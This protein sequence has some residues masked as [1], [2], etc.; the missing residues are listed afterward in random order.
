MK[1]NDLTFKVEGFTG[2]Q[3]VHFF[4]NGYG[5][6]IVRGPYTYGG[7]EGLWELAVL[8][9]TDEEWELCYDTPITSDVIGGINKEEID[10]LLNQVEELERINEEDKG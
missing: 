4:P 6:S 2:E 10:A 9:G 5:V 1:F 3:A 8:I 7:K